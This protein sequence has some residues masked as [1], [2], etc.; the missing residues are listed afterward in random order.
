MWTE[1]G[2]TR[3]P[4]RT[5]G[6]NLIDPICAATPDDPANEIV[7]ASRS[8]AG[9]HVQM[10]TLESRSFAANA[11]DDLDLRPN[12]SPLDMF[13]IGDN[14]YILVG[15]RGEGGISLF[16]L[17]MQTRAWSEVDV[18]QV[19]LVNLPKREDVIVIRLPDGYLNC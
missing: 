10:L 4:T 1:I 5:N 3:K 19:S 8:G 7:V 15:N 6:E 11:V 14:V 9:M 16:S 18:D 2:F 12:Q 13:T 17:D